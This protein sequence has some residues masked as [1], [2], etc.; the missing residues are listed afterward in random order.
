MFQ[1][2]FLAVAAPAATKSAFGG[3]ST[4]L[5]IMVGI[6]VVFYFILIFPE[7]QRRK[8]LKKQLEALKQGEEVITT[9]GII[10]TVD[11][12]DRENNI[13]HLKTNEAK[14]KVRLSAIVSIISK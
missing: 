2:L 8:K 6:F 13:V 1:Q 11:F 10:G 12:I 14:I 4:Q 3:N 5:L 7:S 9:G